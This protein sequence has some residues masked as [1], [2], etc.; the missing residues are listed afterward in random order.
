MS[1]TTNETT[2]E[3]ALAFQPAGFEEIPATTILTR[4]NYYDGKFLRADDLRLEQDYH[5]SVAELGAR[6]GGSGL[7]Y[8][9]D[10]S[11]ASGDELT[12]GGG[13]A[14]DPAG[15]VL[16][17]PGSFSVGLQAVVDATA[18]MLLRMSTFGEGAGTFAVCA[19]DTATP[20]APA[21]GVELYVLSIAH[22]EEACGEEDVF[23]KLCDDGCATSTDRANVL[24]GIVLRARPFRPSTPFAVSK[25]VQLTEKHIRS[26]LASAAFADE[27]LVVPSLISKAGLLGGAWCSGAAAPSGWEVPI[28]VVGKLTST[29]FVDEWIVRR[30]RMEAPPR[31]Y[32]AW[33]MAMR[34]WDAFLAQVLQFQC[35]LPS[36]LAGQGGGVTDPCA[37]SRDA[38]GEAVR[39][40]GQLQVALAPPAAPEPAAVET[41]P[42][43]PGGF[44][45]KL[46]GIVRLQNLQSMLSTVLQ[47]VSVASQRILV[48]GG[49]V[50]LPPAGYLPVA[51][52]TTPPV[53][54]QVRRLLGDGVDLRFCV[55][56]PDY[57]PHALEKRQHMDR[58]SLLQG[59]DDPSNKPP[60]DILV[61]NG[62][63]GPVAAQAQGWDAQLA[64]SAALAGSP[65][66]KP[67]LTHVVTPPEIVL[68]GVGRSARVAGGGGELEFAG[69]GATE[70]AAGGPTSGTFAGSLSAS[71]DVDP[72]GLGVGGTF[73]VSADGALA[74]DEAAGAVGVRGSISATLTVQQPA[75]Q[76]PNGTVVTATGT[77]QGNRSEAGAEVA[78]GTGSMQVVVDLTRSGQTYEAKVTSGDG[79]SGG[80]LLWASWQ[81][82]P[83]TVLAAGESEAAAG[84]EPTATAS[85]AASLLGE[86]TPLANPAAA[87]KL[88]AS[89]DVFSSSN[90]LNVQAHDALQTLAKVFSDPGYTGAVAQKLFSATADGGGSAGLTATLDWVLFARRRH[91]DCQTAPP[92]PVA[93]KT[94]G[95]Y[96]IEADG[97]AAYKLALSAVV[98][99]EAVELERVGVRPAGTVSFTAATATLTTPAQA[100]V[101]AWS[102]AQPGGLIAAVVVATNETDEAATLLQQRVYAYQTA[103]ASVSK[104]DANEQFFTHALLSSLPSGGVD[105]QIVLITQPQTIGFHVYAAGNSD[106][107]ASLARLVEGGITFDKYFANFEKANALIDLGTVTFADATATV[108]ANALRTLAEANLQNGIERFVVVSQSGA[109]AEPENDQA[110]AI[111]TALGA[112]APLPNVETVAAGAGIV[113]PADSPFVVVLEA[114]GMLT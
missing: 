100:V 32:W 80:V 102:Q 4:L 3:L 49:I 110:N 74:A 105:G 40:M 63:L 48:D 69:P 88:V 36:A 78:P 93:T 1:T 101:S 12:I 41:L 70:A 75:Q 7:A 56:T 96:V 31:R 85:N 64:F 112:T 98:H 15:R 18:R 29:T 9:F 73:T 34:P 104:P 10:V 66:Y 89:S 50:E 68:H 39:Y 33:T 62:T 111:M 81:G 97:S 76:T 58:I 28:A 79:G 21:A 45:T 8:G 13:L 55:T 67:V 103:I 22:A 20:T 109:P 26:Q 92:P 43:E 59:L 47:E 23:G 27:R 25:V 87:A 44:L 46:G 82:S 65:I 35:Q 37:Q 113:W 6:A 84:A 52:G 54:V 24:E 51:P 17:L 94:Y 57:I 72:F 83:L 16:Y 5:R 30:E 90:Q 11:L 86:K 99:D 19:S 108:E 71:F 91:K 42:A 14:F 2:T 107:A 38:L 106:A 53:D 114:P 61:P 95:V 77:L 60:V